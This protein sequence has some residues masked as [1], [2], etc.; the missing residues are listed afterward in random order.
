[1]YNLEE[2][3]KRPSSAREESPSFNI[4]GQGP[5]FFLKIRVPTSAFEKAVAS[6]SCPLPPGFLV[7][8]GL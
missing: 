5:Y 7:H 3:H 2:V 4:Y 1:M 6:T 8:G